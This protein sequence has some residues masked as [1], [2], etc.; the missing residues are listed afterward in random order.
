MSISTGANIGGDWDESALPTTKT[1]TTG[2]NGAASSSSALLDM[3]TA[4]ESRLNEKE[5]IKEKLRVEETK[6]QLAAAREGM[7]KEQE[8]KKVEKEAK[9]SEKE[10]TEVRPTSSRFG[11]AASSIAASG[12]AGSKWVPPHLRSAG[13]GSGIG[14]GFRSMN[15]SGSASNSGFRNKVNTD[16]E[17]LFPDLATADKIVKQE[18]EQQKQKAAAR[19]AKPSGISPW[20][21][22]RNKAKSDQNQTG[23]KVAAVDKMKEEPI[24]TQQKK[25]IE[26]AS[27][28]VVKAAT[29]VAIPT[30]ASVAAGLKKKPKKKKKDL[31][32][33]KAA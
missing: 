10:F 12:G 9:K 18:E 26:A 25:E 15:M 24:V 16:D 4:N 13:G 14:D 21:G 8:R 7:K 11:A 32:T 19:K 29:P 22:S 3:K 2:V 28:P 30:A 6:K 23:E 31:S 1:T 27:V 5:E 33:F 20:G 17:E